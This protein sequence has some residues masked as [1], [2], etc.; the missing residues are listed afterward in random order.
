MTFYHNPVNVSLEYIYDLK[1]PLIPLLD[2][3]LILLFTVIW[4]RYVFG[5]FK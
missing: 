3:V 5:Y 4:F 2:L 1:F